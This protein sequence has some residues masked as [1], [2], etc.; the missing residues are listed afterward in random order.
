MIFK[1]L[2][3]T[4]L[5]LILN[6]LVF[7][8]MF[9]IVIVLP[10]IVFA[11]RILVLDFELND[12]TL[13]PNVEQELT[14]VSMLRPLLADELEVRFDHTAPQP[15]ASAAVEAA[16]GQGYVFDRP[17]VAAR[18]GR[19]VDA[20]WVVSGRLHKASHL[21]VYLKAQ[22]IDVHSGKMVYDFVVELKGWGE[23]L[24][25]KGTEALAMQIQDAIEEL[26]AHSN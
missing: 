15:P 12:L 3:K 18:L 21:F 11:E 13:Y 2:S 5:K 4:R 16:Q 8:P 17:D 24:T 22:L 26:P 1:F 10:S 20:D 6:R 19:E 23:K 7:F 9:V 25:R 14:R